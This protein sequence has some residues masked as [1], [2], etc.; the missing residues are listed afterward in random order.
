[1]KFAA[2][3]GILFVLSTVIFGGILIFILPQ[4]SHHTNLRYILWKHHLYPY[5]SGGAFLNV[6]VPFRLSL[7]GKSQQEIMTYFP[8]LQSPKQAGSYEMANSPS[9]I[10]KTYFWL[11]L[12]R[13]E[14]TGGKLSDL[15]LVKG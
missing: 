8:S 10:G 9:S 5:E 12:W 2:K 11:G 3:A 1:M 6:D 14:F 15:R 7:I 13:F 4:N